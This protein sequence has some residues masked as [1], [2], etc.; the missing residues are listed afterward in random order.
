MIDQ[1][2]KLS[3]LIMLMGFRFSIRIMPSFISLFSTS[4]EVSYELL[5]NLIVCVGALEIQVLNES[6]LKINKSS[7]FQ[8]LT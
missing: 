3:A 7:R 2:H 4:T 8:P 6:D 5:A 1:H